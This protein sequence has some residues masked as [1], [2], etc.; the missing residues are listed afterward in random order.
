MRKKINENENENEAVVET[1]VTAEVEKASKKKTIY[2]VEKGTVELFGIEYDI[3]GLPE[4]MKKR[5]MLVGAVGC[6]LKDCTAGMKDYSDS[7]KSA[8]VGKVYN[9]LKE[10][11]WN[12][13][14]RCSVG[15]QL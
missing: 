6:K 1:T 11:N 8:A 13:K 7:E 12:V 9:A 4:E 14:G 5:L 3:Y 15:C 10:G 2:S